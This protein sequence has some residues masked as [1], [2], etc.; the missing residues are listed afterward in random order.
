MD[1]LSNVKHRYPFIMVDG[2]IESKYME[3]VVGFKNISYNEPWTQG[4]YPEKIVFPGVLII[5]AIGQVSSFMFM[6]EENN[7]KLTND[8]GLG[9]LVTVKQ[10]KFIRSVFPGDKLMIRVELL[11]KVDNYITVQG[12]CYVEDEK[13]AEGKLSYIV[14]EDN[15]E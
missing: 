15:H 2:I 4:H 5:E 8:N 13:V 6:K 12:Y 1:I 14:K 10:M 9:Y 3:Y 7:E 11:S